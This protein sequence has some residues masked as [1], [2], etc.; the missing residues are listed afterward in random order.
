MA[1]Y[2]RKDKEGKLNSAALLTGVIQTAFLTMGRKL[3]SA[4]LP[5]RLIAL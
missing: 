1:N 3:N 2:Q 5:P 4:L